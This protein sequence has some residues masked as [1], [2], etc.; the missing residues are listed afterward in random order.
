M[1]RTGVVAQ[2]VEG[3]EAAEAWLAAVSHTSI[4]NWLGPSVAAGSCGEQRQWRRQQ[5]QARPSGK[6][7]NRAARL[8]GTALRAGCSQGPA[9]C[10]AYAP[11]GRPPHTWGPL[12]RSTPPWRS[13]PPAPRLAS[14]SRRAQ[15]HCRSRAAAACGKPCVAGRM[16]NTARQS[17]LGA[18]LARQ[19]VWL[20]KRLP[21]PHL[22]AGGT[23]SS[24]S[25]AAASP[26]LGRWPRRTTAIATVGLAAPFGCPA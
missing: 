23:Q 3:S 10:A 6:G 7:V 4:S 16:Q 25:S 9:V 26:L 17:R 1:S 20:Q 18:N 14:H 8:Q 19:W 15:G 22:A 13:R 11:A 24:S 21:A 5:G 12:S 2:P